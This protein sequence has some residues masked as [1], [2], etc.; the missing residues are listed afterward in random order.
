[1]VIQRE[2]EFRLWGWADKGEKV[3]VTFNSTERSIRADRNGKWMLT[4]PA[5]KAG[6]PYEII[7]QGTNRITLKNILFGD[8]WICSGQSNM[9]WPLSLL[10]DSLTECDKANFPEIRIFQVPCTV[11]YAPAEDLPDGNWNE[12]NPETIRQFSAAG[13]Y[14]G[15]ELHKELNIPIG[16]VNSSCGGTN[17]EM[18]TSGKALY[19]LDEFANIA[20]DLESFDPE[21]ATALKKREIE[22]LLDRHT[23][24]APGL[25]GDSAYWADPELSM[26]G[27]GHVALPRQWKGTDLRSIEGVLWFRYNFDLPEEVA[28]RGITLELGPIDDSDMTWVNG[29]LVGQTTMNQYTNRIYHVP[30]DLLREDQNVIAIRISNTGR[31]RGFYS[32]P[33]YFRIVSGDFEIPLADTWRY[34]ISPDGLQVKFPDIIGPDRNPSLLFNGMIHPLHNLSIKGFIWYQGEAN[35]IRPTG[36][37]DLFPMLITDWRQHWG[38]ADLPYLFVQLP[39]YMHPRKQPGESHWAELREAQAMALDLPATGMAVAIDI[40]E[41]ENLHPP[42]KLEVGKRLA[43]AAM[44]IAYGKELVYSGPLFRKME[45]SGKHAILTFDHVGSGLAAKDWYGYLKGFTIAGADGTFRWARAFIKDNQVYVYN[46]LIKDP[47]AVR[48][49]W[50]DNPDDANLYNKEGLPAVPFRTVRASEAVWSGDFDIIEIE[51]PLDN[52]IQKA[53]F[54]NTKSAEPKPLIV[55]LH[56]WSGDY[57]QKDPLSE[58]CQTKD[59]NY[60]HPDFRGPNHTLEACCSDLVI[61]DID[62]AISYAISNANVDTTQIFVIGV[63]GGGY[64]TL[65][66]FMKSK[67]PIRKF[68]AWAAISDLPAW[69]DQ[70]RIRNNGYADDILNCTD[71][72]NGKLNTEKA[73]ERSPFYWE[74]PAD[75]LSGTELNIFAGIYDGIQGSVPITHSIN[76]YNKLLAE[77]HVTDLSK[78]VSDAEKLELLEYRRPVH[79]DGKIADRDLCLVKEYGGIKL[80]IFTGNHEML[81]EYALDLLLNQ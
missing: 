52:H 11:Q 46:D 59:L 68:S 57:T 66:M 58:L 41:A 55:S 28:N 54:Y 75:K 20:G 22:A 45:I 64:A 67:H 29:H 9:G 53:Y 72:E 6:G 36:Y 80:I 78:F 76:F 44:K 21:N 39:N 40:G 81:P 31:G 63:S 32:L 18:W 8:V 30:S 43:L 34:R 27:W 1:M 61:N 38:K 37:G 23:G 3:S 49:G 48:Y 15:R 5:M 50:A 79:S 16:L 62:E 17:I 24:T 47:V 14:F 26:T 25:V 7:I 42:N 2:Q 4:L 65:C 77:L 10:P 71:S 13:Y 69:Y 33:R 19:T 12:C 70:S 73:K 60:I 35:T 74:F 51:S 56:T